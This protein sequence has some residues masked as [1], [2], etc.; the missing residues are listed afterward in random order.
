[1]IDL[2]SLPWLPEQTPETAGLLTERKALR[3]LP[4]KQLAAIAGRRLTA[5]GIRA[6]SQAVIF[7]RAAAIA[8]GFTPVRLCIASQAM[9]EFIGENLVVA[10]LRFGLVIGIVNTEF[11]QLADL[12]LGDFFDNAA[13]GDIDFTFVGLDFRQMGFRDGLADDPNAAQ[14]EVSA[15]LAWLNQMLGGIRAKTGAP[16]MVQNLVADPGSWVGS[17]DQFIAGSVRWLCDSFNRGLAETLSGTPH[18]MLDAAQIAADIGLQKWHDPGMWYL[19]KLGQSQSVM[20]YLGHRM[21]ALLA[22][23]RGKAKRLL[24]L[25]L[26]NTVWGG[27]I[28]DDGIEGIRIGHG[29]AAGEA[30]LDLQ[31]MAKS[32]RN[33][34]VVLAVCSKNEDAVA[35][36][37]FNDHPG[38]VLKIDDFAAFRANWDD[39][40]SNIAHIARILELGHESCVFIDDNPAEREIVRRNLPDIAVPELGGNP[41]EYVRT[42]MAAGYF[43]AIT[44][45]AEDRRRADMYRDNARRI[46]VME[47]VADMDTY[48]ASLAMKIS[49]KPFDRAGRSRIA[50]L[51][52]K[53][54]QYNLTSLRYSEADV[55]A[56]E[57]DAAAYTLQVGLSDSFGDNGMIS[58]VICRKQ[59]Q[60][61]AIDTWLMSCRVLKRR[62]EEQVLAHLVQ[63]VARGGARTLRGL[64]LPTPRNGIVKD[65]YQ[66]LGF[67]LQPDHAGE[68]EVWTLDIQKF[69]AAGLHDLP[70]DIPPDA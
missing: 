28:G 37:P 53:S 6:L 3:G 54:N 30:H 27:V 69:L 1:M 64:F 7:D 43:E 51:I 70:F 56:L 57:G 16:C 22:A 13:H 48:L 36:Q 60:V 10:G 23:A 19:A 52:N 49:L 15:K 39:K 8:E 46:E 21:A 25:D 32:L 41:A 58:V 50:Q 44:V 66:R 34:G 47:Q 31:R 33:R 59:G 62:V 61:W 42:V 67:T 2:L 29:S 45:S 17:A 68:G 14:A 38:M 18:F 55:E 63:A 24:I 12:A 9:S 65:H 35:R 20:P 5:S 40:A 4:L 26:D 11:N